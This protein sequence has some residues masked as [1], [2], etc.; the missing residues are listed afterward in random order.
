MDLFDGDFSRG[1]EVAI[2][3]LDGSILWVP[4]GKRPVVDVGAYVPGETGKAVVMTGGGRAQELADIGDLTASSWVLPGGNASVVADQDTWK[5]GVHLADRIDF[6][7]TANARVEQ[8]VAEVS[9][10]DNTNYVFPVWVRV[11]SGTEPFRLQMLDK[12]GSIVAAANLTATTEWRRFFI[13][14][15]VGTGTSDPRFR[16]RNDGDGQ[17]RSLF[18]AYPNLT[19]GQFPLPT[20]RGASLGSTVWTLPQGDVPQELLDGSYKMTVVPFGGN[21]AWSVDDPE[22]AS[23]FLSYS[24]QN[25]DN[26]FRFGASS[27]AL[28]ECKE[29]GVQRVGT[30]VVTY[31]RLTPITFIVEANEGRLTVQGVDGGTVVDEQSPWSWALGDDLGIGGVASDPAGSRSF[32]GLITAIEAA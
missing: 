10:V 8:S 3:R 12:A 31:D 5:D 11:A 32:V 1:S 27:N 26:A 6:T 14:G 30:G 4:A 21:G 22:F 17:A 28:I 7:A 24:T 19:L 23:V 9:L 18:V 15:N 16:V 29:S 2:R 25:N 13:T 20:I